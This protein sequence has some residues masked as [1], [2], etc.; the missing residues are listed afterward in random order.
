MIFDTEKTGPSF[1]IGPKAHPTKQKH[2]SRLS[3]L[4]LSLK[5]VSAA[6]RIQT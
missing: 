5:V 2:I 6:S 4:P 3:F 1:F